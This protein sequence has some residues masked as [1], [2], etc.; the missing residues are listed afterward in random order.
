M[1][2]VVIGKS[3]QL[4]SE[5]ASS[6]PQNYQVSAYGRDQ[7]DLSSPHQLD[8]LLTDSAADWVINTAAHTAVDQAESEAQAAQALNC[9]AAKTLAEASARHNCKLIHLSTDFVFDG[10]HGSPYA[11]D[12][13]TNPLSV[14]GKTKLAGE[15]AVLAALPSAIVIRTSWVFSQFGNNFVKTMLRLMGERDSLGVV[16]DQ[17]GSPTSAHDLSQFIWQLI[18]LNAPPQGLLHWTNAGMASWYDFAVAIEELGCGA[19]LLTS[20]TDIKPIPTSAYPT[21]AARPSY[22]VLDKS[23]AWSITPVA[24]HWRA[25]LNDVITQLKNA[26]NA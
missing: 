16:A 2:I 14:Y 18:A 12:S 26:S 25:A 9:D 24:R 19:G 20:T 22:S 1:R 3:G 11:T 8:Q 5:L 13:A 15:H 4:A 21:P 10:N 17:V 7:I 6:A 23:V